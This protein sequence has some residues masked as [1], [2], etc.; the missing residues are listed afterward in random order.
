[1]EKSD[2]VDILKRADAEVVFT[3]VDGTERVMQCTLR[4]SFLKEV[5]GESYNKTP[6][7]KENDAV[8]AVFDLEKRA[9]RSIRLDSIKE[10]Q[11]NISSI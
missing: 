1:M 3:K 5:L 11:Y 2:L 8:L 9:W 10:I 7:K 4:E 6:T